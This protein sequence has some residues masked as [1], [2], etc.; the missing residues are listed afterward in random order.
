MCCLFQGQCLLNVSGDA[1]EVLY[2]DDCELDGMEQVSQRKRT[3][4]YREANTQTPVHLT[5]QRSTSASDAST[6]TLTSYASFYG[7]EI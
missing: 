3:G 4:S 2:D 7:T 1:V 6:S 5:R